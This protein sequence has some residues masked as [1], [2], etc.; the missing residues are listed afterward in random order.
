L[1]QRPVPNLKAVESA[2]KE[3]SGNENAELHHSGN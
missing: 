2:S 3:V 1:W